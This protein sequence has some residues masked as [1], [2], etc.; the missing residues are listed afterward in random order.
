M[1]DDG[2]P[3]Y[4]CESCVSVITEFYNFSVIYEENVA[5]LKALSEVKQ[6]G[7]LENNEESEYVAYETIDDQA[8]SEE[9]EKPQPGAEDR[10]EQII[11]VVKTE[12]EEENSNFVFE[13]QEN[14]KTELILSTYE[15]ETV[16]SEETGISDETEGTTQS[17]V[18]QD[19]TP[20]IIEKDGVLYEEKTKYECKDCGDT[21]LFGTGIVSHMYKKHQIQ[22]IDPDEYGVKILVKLKRHSGN[23]G[24]HPTIKRS[25]EK[26]DDWNPKCVICKR[27]FDTIESLKEHMLIHKTFVCEVCG[28]SFIKKSYLDDHR[29]A[30]GTE[31]RYKCKFCNKCFKRRTVLVKHKRIHTHPRQCVCEIC[32]KRFNDN[33]TLKTHRLLLHTKERKFKCMICNQSFPLKP[34]LDKHIKRHLKRENGE[35]DFACDQCDMRYRDKSS[36]NRHQFSKHS[37]LNHKVKCE[38]CGKEYTSTTNL[39][40]HRRIHHRKLLN[41]TCG[42][43]T[44]D[45]I[46]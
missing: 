36:L 43:E 44:S 1:Y 23:P 10:N 41:F 42:D 37:G 20:R 14:V 31:K 32:G 6:V 21:F 46:I 17:S 7:L 8:D 34:T 16:H 15:E 9:K 39:Y 40:K 25:Y 29:E 3:R 22:D 28:N 27:V 12:T 19:K 13:H 33:G 24:E 30:H 38:D 5:Q 4:L 18:S 35:K 45:L 2:L 26:I 11:S